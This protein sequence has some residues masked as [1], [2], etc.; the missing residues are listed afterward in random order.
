MEQFET[1]HIKLLS[2]LTREVS[3]LTFPTTVMLPNATC[4]FF[5]TYQYKYAAEES[6]VCVF[7]VFFFFFVLFF[8]SIVF[9]DSLKLYDL[10]HW[11]S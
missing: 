11:V 3:I 1:D 5:V 10:A 6:V 4:T 7:C 9:H 2:G 8:K